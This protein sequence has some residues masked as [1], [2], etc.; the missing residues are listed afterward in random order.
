MIT[1]FRATYG[2][3]DNSHD[4]IAWDGNDAPPNDL[5]GLTD[6]PAG[7]IQPQEKWWPAINCG[8]LGQEWWGIWVVEPD[9]RASRGGMVK[10]EALL[11]K[12]E[13][14][15]SVANLDE[16]I[17]SLINGDVLS[18]SGKKELVFN[19]LANEL[20]QNSGI[21]VIDSLETLPFLISHLWKRLSCEERVNF[22]V[23][24]KFIPPQLSGT[25]NSTFY[26]VPASCINQ[27]YSDNVVFVDSTSKQPLSRGA[28]FLIGESQRSDK[29]LSD[30]VQSCM[31]NARR[32]GVMARG[33]DNI[34]KFRRDETFSHAINALRTVIGFAE[35]AE[36]AQFV[37]L[38][39]LDAI[40]KH[41]KQSALPD[42]VIRIR[43]ISENAFLPKQLPEDEL[44]NWII[45][46]FLENDIET[47][48]EFFQKLVPSKSRSWWHSS[49]IAGIK[50]VVESSLAGSN[51]LSW[52]S[53]NSFLPIADKLIFIKKDIDNIL[54]EIAKSS[55]CT[56]EEIKKL[57]LLANDKKWP[58]MYAWSNHHLTENKAISMQIDA[59]PNWRKGIPYLIEN[60]QRG[61]LLDAIELSEL[62]SFSLNFVTK[63]LESPDLLEGI[64]INKP[65][66]F[67]LWKMQLEKGGCFY[68]S[69][70][71]K[72][73]FKELLYKKLTSGLSNH[74]F[75]EVA[76]ESANLFLHDSCANEVWNRLNIQEKEELAKCVVQV[77]NKE[78][79][80]LDEHKFVPIE[81][82]TELVNYLDSAHIVF[83]AFVLVCLSNHI[84][85]DERK[86]FSWLCKT[87]SSRW[88]QNALNKLS[89]LI[90]A[91][92]WRN[93]VTLLFKNYLV[94]SEFNSVVH[95]CSDFLNL[96]DSWRLRFYRGLASPSDRRELVK[97]LADLGA[98]LAPDRLEYFW[99]RA[100]GEKKSLLLKGT[101]ADIWLHAVQA[102]NQ[103]ALNYG[104]TDLVNALLKE[105]P[106]NQELSEIR[107][108]LS[109]SGVV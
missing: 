53:L 86:I 30:L 70:T 83:P 15:A 48:D 31:S 49:V 33:A 77:L 43:N 99:V 80:L 35:K 9:E 10:S 11:W 103:G 105:Y 106:N 98:E 17:I 3:K 29:T 36:E 95:D 92:K 50:E 62:S 20:I 55:N 91:N 90:K 104:M 34:E 52:L 12:K 71:N 107:R 5:L 75:R 102:A 69:G 100:G 63:V 109:L 64:D 101:V 8:P 46:N 16:Y 7:H 41:L 32:L 76:S 94:H 67:S 84:S 47:Q 73:L 2:F 38:E 6:R 85:T 89:S 4:L 13:S 44:K 59:M 51:L 25:L 54:F 42:E 97:R 23:Q 61:Q 87:N 39:L 74:V 58:Q 88:D 65:G 1:P 28:K 81:L 96:L 37:K 26:G 19:N 18:P 22:S 66:A 21:L 27:W 57:Q 108:M 14:L 40:K 56:K 72:D 93:L 82:K 60:M 68:P 78:P 24:V 79:F 45:Q